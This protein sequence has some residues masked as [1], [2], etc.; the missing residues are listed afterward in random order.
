[1][2]VWRCA[3][4]RPVSAQGQGPADRAR[5]EGL[6]LAVQLLLRRGWVPPARHAAIAAV[7][8]PPGVPRHHGGADLGD[9]ARRNSSASGAAVAAYRGVAANRCALAGM[10]AHDVRAEPVLAGGAGGVHAAG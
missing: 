1:M 3:P 2:F 5:Q 6:L 8:R 4:L 10:V 9:A 7:S